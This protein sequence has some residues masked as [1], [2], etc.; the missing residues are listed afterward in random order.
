MIEVAVAT[1]SLGA[2]PHSAWLQGKAVSFSL[3]QAATT[4]VS[5]ARLLLRD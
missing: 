2:E 5:G 3:G 1:Q 4:S